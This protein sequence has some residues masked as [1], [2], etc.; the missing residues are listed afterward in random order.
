MRGSAVNQDGR[1][2][3]LTAPNGLAQ[4]AVIRQALDDA[5]AWQGDIDFIE[6]HG[7]GTPLGDPIEIEALAEVFGAGR[8][9]GSAFAVGSVKTNIGHLEGAA[10]IAGLI[11]AVLALRHGA[12][13]PSLHLRQLNPH[14]GLDGAPFVFPDRAAA[15]A[16][17]RAA[18]TGRSQLVRLVGHE[19]PHRAGR[20]AGAASGRGRPARR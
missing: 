3:G 18:P 20:G 15:V 14:I 7:T 6:A 4:Q 10:G 19:R 5:Q 9:E 12:I 16:G 8:A 17:R 2:A 13:P 11:K 1:S